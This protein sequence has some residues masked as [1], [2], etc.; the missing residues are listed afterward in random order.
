M[1]R[2]EEIIDPGFDSEK[3]H[4]STHDFK[5]P[6][7]KRLR[8][9][10]KAFD[11]KDH[12]QHGKSF[13]TVIEVIVKS[14]SAKQD[15]DH[16]HFV[17][18]QQQKNDAKSEPEN[19]ENNSHCNRNSAKAPT[20]VIVNPIPVDG[21]SKNNTLPQRSKMYSID[22]ILEQAADAIKREKK[23]TKWD[24]RWNDRLEELKE[25]KRKHGHCNVVP[26][27]T[28]WKALGKWVYSQRHRRKEGQL[29]DEQVK[30]LDDIDFQWNLRPR[31]EKVW[32][33]NY[34]EFQCQP[35]I[36]KTAVGISWD[37]RYKELEEFKKEQGH[38]NVSRYKKPWEKLGRWVYDQK[39][40]KQKGSLAEYRVKKL[41]TPGIDWQ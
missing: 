27:H 33:E 15:G 1:V 12:L 19:K 36:T 41:E 29:S 37:D 22:S 32:Q 26:S 14:Q 24:A 7:K 31:K 38:C 21:S 16:E 9:E 18:G 39:R 35:E 28:E 20:T 2:I 23:K 6:P 34:F 3:Y 25:F 10:P 17:L 40:K 11:F 4:Q 8:F 5:S 13:A 30:L